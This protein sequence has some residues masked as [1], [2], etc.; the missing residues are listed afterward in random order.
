M[1]ND[2]KTEILQELLVWT[3]IGFYGTVK[4]MLQDVLDTDNK[5]LAYQA[6]DGETSI[7]AI[8]VAAGIGS[9]TANELLR[10][11]LNLGL[12]EVT[13]DGRRRRLFD[14]TNFGLLPAEIVKKKGFGN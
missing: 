13:G 10:Q 6:A 12:M 1:A 14:L 9:N 11:C 3:R 2:T 7:E 8:K 5:R 4:D